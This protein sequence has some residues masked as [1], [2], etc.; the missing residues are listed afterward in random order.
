MPSSACRL[1][2]TSLSF[3]DGIPLS[4]RPGQRQGM[5]TLCFQ[6]LFRIQR[7]TRHQMLYHIYVRL[8]GLRVD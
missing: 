4:W 2:R 1:T 7:L 6:P 5:S 8:N 3:K